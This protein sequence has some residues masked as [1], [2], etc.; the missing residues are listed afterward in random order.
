MINGFIFLIILIFLLGKINL[1]QVN[2]FIFLRITNPIHYMTEFTGEMANG[3]VNID[4]I[5]K[6]IYQTFSQYRFNL[7]EL[8]IITSL[9]LYNL[10]IKNNLIIIFFIFILN[11]LIMNFRYYD[12][13]HLYYMFIYLLLFVESIKK[14]ENKLSKKLIYTVLIVIFINSLN[15][16]IIK[17]NNILNATFNRENG[18]VKVCKEFIYKIPSDTYENVSYIKY[19][20]KKFD[21]KNLRK[22][23]DEII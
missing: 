7:I 21:D 13:Y 1:L 10:K 17:D 11:A 20:H 5:L 2:D 23:C 6:T 9:V 16:F 12:V 19:Y 18:M 15:S 14:I 4:Y 22:I 8:F 3:I